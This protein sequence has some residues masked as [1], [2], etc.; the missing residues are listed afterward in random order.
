[1]IIS[2][3][4]KRQ[5]YTEFSKLDFRDNTQL[6]L[7][8]YGLRIIGDVLFSILFFIIVQQIYTNDAIALESL[9][10]IKLINVPD[11]VSIVLI[12]IAIVSVLWLHELIHATVFFIH[13]GAPPHIGMNGPIIFSS[14][15]GYMN[16]RNA[17]VI[18]VLA[19]FIVISILGVLLMFIV[20]T[21]VLAWIFIPTVANPAAA[22]GDFMAVYWLL[23]LSDDTQIE[24][25]GDVLI[26]YDPII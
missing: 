13:I 9:I 2:S 17:M 15:I 18:N 4:S 25:H 26:A 16:T 10:T 6:M 23:S 21:S 3:L 5:E 11:I 7:L 22:G 19:P 12:V 14:A 1:M 24:D 20:P 8:S